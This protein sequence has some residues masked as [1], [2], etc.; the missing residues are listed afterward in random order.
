MLFGSTGVLIH[1]QFSEKANSRMEKM[2]LFWG[3]HFVVIEQLLLF[4]ADNKSLKELLIN[5]SYH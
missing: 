1:L 4:G 3:T 2:V 5:Y